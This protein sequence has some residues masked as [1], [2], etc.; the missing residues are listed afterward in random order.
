MAGRMQADAHAAVLDRLAIGQRLQHDVV[1]Q[2]CAQHAGAVVRGQVVP[3][4]A[5]RMVGVRMRD[6]R[7]VHRP[8]RVDVEVARRAVQALRPLDDEVVL[9]HRD[10]C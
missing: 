7:A 9:I 6:H 3:V 4:A 2:P 8:P 5:T 1:A 10:Q